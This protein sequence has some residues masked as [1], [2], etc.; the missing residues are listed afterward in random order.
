MFYTVM[1]Y[2]CAFAFAGVFQGLADDTLLP[3]L[4]SAL[5]I[6]T[7]SVLNIP[8]LSALNLNTIISLASPAPRPTLPLPDLPID[9]PTIKTTDIY[10]FLTLEAPVPVSF[11]AHGS[12]VWYKFLGHSF[13]L[14]A[15]VLAAFLFL[16]SWYIYTTIF[17]QKPSQVWIFIFLYPQLYLH[18]MLVSASIFIVQQI[19]RVLQPQRHPIPEHSI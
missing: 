18:E 16:A 14:F 1:V 5:N 12:S 13:G 3:F 17:E 15:T 8:T 7:L 10:P 9:Q 4:A 19:H 11:F 2:F 6:P